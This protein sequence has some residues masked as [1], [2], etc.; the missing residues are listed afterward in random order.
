MNFVYVL[1]GWEGSASDS[2]ILRD[3]ISRRNNLK[4]P[5]EF[6]PEE[7]TLL[8]EEHVLIGEDHGGNEDGDDD[9]IESVEAIND[10][11]AW[12]DNLTNEMYN[13][14]MNSREKMDRHVWT[15]EEIEAFVSFME[16]LVIEGGRA[17]AG[18]FRPGSFENLATKMNEKFPVCSG[19][20]W[21]DVK[22]YVVMDNKE[23]LAAYL[24]DKDCILQGSPFPLYPRLKKIFCKV[25][26]SGVDAVS[27]NDVEEEVQKD[28]DEETDDEEFFMFNSNHDFSESLPQQSNYVGSSSKRKQE[29]KPHSSKATKDTNMMKELTK[30]LKYVFD[31]QGKRLDAFAQ[32]M[33]NTHEEKR[34][35]DMLSEL[36]FT[37]DKIISIALKFSTNLQLEKTF[38]S[39]GHNQK[40]GFARAILHS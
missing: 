32:A 10:W 15:D 4:I 19:F 2:R 26:A 35:G 1:S 40:A 24:K 9:M 29:K 12:R 39:L 13:E 6:D 14:W 27:G 20:G 7:D 34:I 8:D 36:G 23:I 33:I 5:I 38:W 16:E 21:D 25:R 28:G 17:D 31:Q 3:A 37:D 11:T 18:Q 30:T 22:Q